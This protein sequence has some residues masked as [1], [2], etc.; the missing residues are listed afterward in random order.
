MISLD[1]TLRGLSAKVDKPFLLSSRLFYLEAS[2]QFGSPVTS[3]PLKH[4]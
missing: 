2:A 3:G 4:R 1:G